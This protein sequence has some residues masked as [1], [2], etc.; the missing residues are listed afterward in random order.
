MQEK[1]SILYPVY[2]AESENVKKKSSFITFTYEEM[3]EIANTMFAVDNYQPGVFSKFPRLTDEARNLHARIHESCVCAC[4][5]LDE[6][7][8]HDSK[9]AGKK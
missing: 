3:L 7:M 2:V 4:M 6:A 1:P 8:L 5:A 9:E